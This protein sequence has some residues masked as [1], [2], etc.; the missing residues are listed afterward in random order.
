[1]LAVDLDPP[2]GEV[3]LDPLD[4]QPRGEQPVEHADVGRLV[5]LVVGHRVFV[6]RQTLILDET[7]PASSRPRRAPRRPPALYV[8]RARY[9]VDLRATALSDEDMA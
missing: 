6:H 7:R 1:M 2:G 3:L 4:R 5:E 9:L 8:V